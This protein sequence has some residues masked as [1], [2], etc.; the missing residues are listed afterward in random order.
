ML[1]V[2]STTYKK[3]SF[4][5]IFWI[6]L[7]SVHAQ[8]ENSPYSRY[9][10]GDILPGANIL[11]R[12]MAGVSAAYSDGRSV[13]FLN[14]AS[15]SNL[16]QFTTLDF[17]VELNN[18]TL[19]ALDP[20]RK[21]SSASPIISYLQLGIPLSRKRNW[22]MNIGLR[23]ITRINYKIERNERITGID[24]LNTLFEGNGGT[25]QVYGGTGFGIKN[26]SIGVNVGYLFGS[27]NFS[28]RK[29][30]IPDSSDVFYYQSNHE[31]QANY[32]GLLVNGGIQW[33][34]KLDT[35]T[36]LRLGAYG[37]LKKKLNASKDITSGTFQYNSVTGAI[38]SLDVALNQKGIQGEVNYPSSFGA[39][40][41]FDKFGKWM[42]GADLT[43]TNWD[44]YR[45]FGEPDQVQNSW[46]LHVGGQIIPK[47]G[48]N[49]L[50]YVAYRAGFSY[51][52]DYIKIDK[53]LPV[54]GVTAGA[55]FPMRKAAY[56]N[57]FSMINL[58]LEFGQRGNKENLVREN[59]FRLSVGL[60]LSDIWFIKQKY[61]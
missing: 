13:N 8:T 14:P 45:F 42:L 32:N 38:D 55:S 22:G 41:V 56:T 57:Q 15:Y 17:G 37:N 6:F 2:S 5:G 1:L 23:P 21:F 58:G 29:T 59:F 61:D 35:G 30:F 20:P 43:I 24:S 39:G 9:G 26:F 19:R 47:A 28:T 53:D 33:V 60:S 51:G 40:F 34:A 27:K 25:Y 4:L 12:G 31:S 54:W 50:S 3:I 7:F 44:D 10:L 18:R 52:K 16:K 48:K 46:K 11:N 36:Y 49:Y